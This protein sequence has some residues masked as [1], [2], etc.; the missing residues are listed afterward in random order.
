MHAV[1]PP[2]PLHEHWAGQHP[3]LQRCLG[4]LRGECV[5]QCDMPAAARIEHVL[6]LLFFQRVGLRSIG[7]VA[8]GY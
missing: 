5:L 8:D 2:L 1:A 7:H 6:A 3:G 4:P